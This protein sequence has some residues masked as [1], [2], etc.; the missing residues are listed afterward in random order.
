MISKSKEALTD[1]LTTIV[2]LLLTSPV[3]TAGL[4]PTSDYPVSI[5]EES[6]SQ[7]LSKIHELGLLVV[8]SYENAMDSFLLAIS[9]VLVAQICLIEV[10]RSFAASQ[11]EDER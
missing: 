3:F 10:V 9:D 11:L 1:L 5:K 4:G 7:V 6:V 8:D 2:L